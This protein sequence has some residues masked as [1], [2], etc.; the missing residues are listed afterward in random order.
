ML[1]R[2]LQ[3]YGDQLG[4]ESLVVLDD[5]SVDGSTEQL[6]CTVLRLPPEP[7]NQGWARTRWTLAN[8]MSRALLACY[9]VV[10]FSDVDEFL[11]P[12]PDLYG[13]L[14]DY[15]AAR[16][17]T[18]IVAPL[19]LNVLHDPR[20]EPPLDPAQPVLNQRSRVKFAPGMC[21]PLVKAVPADWRYAFHG[22]RAPFTIDPELVMLHLKYYDVD[23]L[24]TVA[25][26]RRDT[27]E[28]QGRGHPESAWPLGPDELSSRLRRWVDHPDGQEIPE[29]DASEV[30]LESI[31]VDHEKGFFRTMGP[32]LEAMED[33]PLRRLP[34][35][36][37]DAF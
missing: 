17:G 34:A 20:S 19:A 26:Q 1:P 24:Q 15:L 14:V 3:Y 11:V 31:V 25:G 27:H 29:F 2:W 7:W 33:F 9:D 16:R 36:F 18:D 22:I 6:P 12:D 8:G 10:I 28:Q 32:Q 35:R 5:N 37:R 21:K 4:V 23:A 30:D 13:G